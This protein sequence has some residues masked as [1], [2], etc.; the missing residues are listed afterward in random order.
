MPATNAVSERSFSVL[1]RIKSYLRSTL[2]QQRLNHLMIFN[3]YKE[4]VDEMD[5]KSIANK[6]VQGNEHRLSVLG[7]FKYLINVAIQHVI[8]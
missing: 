5:L 4:A 3:I 2:T 7:N 1:L 8:T 6:F